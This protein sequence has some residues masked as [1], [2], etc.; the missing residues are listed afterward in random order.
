LHSLLALT[1]A[2][3][4]LAAANPAWADPPGR[5][6]RL[7]EVDGNV[8]LYDEDQGE[9]VQ[10]RRNRPVTEGDRL[11]AERG[12]RATVQIG[13]GTLR[14]DGNTDVEF[15]QLDDSRVQV[16]VHG[17]SVALRVRGSYSVREFSLVTEEGRYE[18]LRPGLYRVD[19]RERSSLGESLDG[20]MRFEASDSMLEIGDG[21]RAEFWQERGATHYAWADR[22]DDR[23]GDWVARE[24]REEMRDRARYVSEEMTGAG[25]LERHGR[26]HTHPEYGAIWYPTVVVAGWAPYRYGHWA[27]IRPWGWTWVDD[28]P[29]GF[30]PFHYGR[31]VHWGGRWGWSPGHYVARPVY[32][33]ALVAWFGGPHVSVSIGIGGGPA[34]GWVPLAPREIYYPGYAHSPYY[35]RG[36]NGTH[37]RWHGPRPR[38]ERPVPTGPIMYT[39]QGVAGGV[40]V[41]PQG[42]MHNRQPISPKVLMPVDARTVATWRSVRPSGS[43]GET[44]RGFEPGNAAP[45]APPPSRV[46]ATPG[47]AVPAAPNAARVTPWGRPTARVGAAQGDGGQAPRVNAAPTIAAQPQTAPAARPFDAREG[48]VDRRDGR[49]ERG[50]RRDRREER[51]DRRDSREERG[52]RRVVAPPMAQQVAP[53]TAMPQQPMQPQYL[54]Q[55]QYPPPAQ[56]RPRDV[57]QQYPAPQRDV[58]QQLPQVQMSAQPRPPQVQHLQPTQQPAARAE[59]PRATV[60][61]VQA[62]Q[63]QVPPAAVV[64]QPRQRQRDDAAER[65]GPER[66]VERDRVE[67]RNG[68][69]RLDE[70]AWRGRDPREQQAR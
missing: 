47:G 59:P 52:D 45:P 19:V 28:A 24:D 48:R 55:P 30:A 17:G 9:W 14:L 46:V 20:T 43:R 25:D 36:V 50:E 62:P 23:F 34:V 5:V 22:S 15:A 53:A 3:F 42:V 16:R 40:T 70:R 18:P 66:S 44:P 29:W 41:V 26:W 31:W 67:Q 4:A 21:R 64:A 33:P 69:H 60:S 51:G 8:W 58:Q 65:R 11:S 68:Q 56:Q 38:Y 27:Y 12:A 2:L 63:A 32:A 6:G 10:A 37:G 61:Q 7:A 39:N 13:G 54:P 1:L 49:E 35:V 57:R